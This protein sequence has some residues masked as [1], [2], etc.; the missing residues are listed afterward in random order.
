LREVTEMFG[1]GENTELAQHNH[2]LVESNF[3]SDGKPLEKLL[4]INECRDHFDCI[5]DPNYEVHVETYNSQGK[6]KTILKPF[7]AP[8]T[9][10]VKEEADKIKN[11]EVTGGQF[12]VSLRINGDEP[13]E[14]VHSGFIKNSSDVDEVKSISEKYC[15]M[16]NQYIQENKWLFQEKGSDKITIGRELS[17]KADEFSLDLLNQYSRKEVDREKRTEIWHD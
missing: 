12:N 5:P 8:N 17:T 14:D 10:I 16:I 7:N 4:R 2:V 11:G 15:M 13:L 9:Y 6:T 3:K 1:I